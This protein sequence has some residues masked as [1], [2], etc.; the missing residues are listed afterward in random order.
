MLLP[1]NSY[2]NLSKKAIVIASLILNYTKASLW[3]QFCHFFFTDRIALYTMQ[4][5][6]IQIKSLVQFIKIIIK[7][8]FVCHTPCIGALQRHTN[9][10][11]IIEFFLYAMQTILLHFLRTL[12]EL[13]LRHMCASSWFR[14]VNGRCTQQPKIL[15]S[16]RKLLTIIHSIPNKVLPQKQ[17]KCS[18][19]YSYLRMKPLTH[20]VYQHGLID[21]GV[22]EES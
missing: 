9:T 1:L 12:F 2:K 7:C 11:H 17:N 18:S 19:T 10:V 13:K 3:R 8:S 22:F 4:C 20:C 6:M 21:F 15:I 14:L 5:V 16:V